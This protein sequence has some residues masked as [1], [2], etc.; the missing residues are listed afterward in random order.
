[1]ATSTS[2]KQSVV[3]TASWLPL[4]VIVLAQMQMAF[5]VNALP[6]SLGPI[7]NDLDAP[8]TAISSALLIY[9]LFVAA[10]VMLGAKI[11]KL[12][13]ERLVFQVSAVAHGA[14]MAL[15]ALATDTSMM[16][17]AQAVAG[18]AAAALVP[19]LV[20]LIAANYQDKQ[21]AQAFGIL[22]SIPAVAS[23]V[24][25]VVA[26]Y[27]ATLLNWRLSFWSLAVLSGVVLV[28]SFRLKNV[29]RTPD[30]KIDVTGV[31]LS[32]MAI[33]FILF[34]FNNI[35]TW[36]L[37]WATPNAPFS[38]LGVSP[39]LILTA[40]GIVLGQ[41]FFS[42]SHHRVA[43][44]K[45]PLLAMEVLDSP[46]EKNAV[47]AFLVAGALGTAVSFLIPL[48]IQ[49]VQGQTPFFTA[50]A[51]VP[52]AIAV[53]IAAIASVRLY[54]RLTPRI[55]GMICFVMIAVGAT[56]VGF[57][58]FNDWGTLSVILGLVI[59][60]LGEGTM[61]TLLF[62]VLVSASPK[63]FAGDVGALRGVANNVSS[64]LGAAFAG[65]VAVGLLAAVITSS[66]QASSLPSS[67]AEELNFDRIDFVS[68][69][70]LETYLAK[71]SATPAQV[72]EAVRINENA[73]LSALRA[74]FILIAIISLLALIPALGLPKYSPT[75][76]PA[77][78][79][80]TNSKKKK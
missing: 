68:N 61:L 49:F 46:E 77:D 37:L 3:Q 41:S 35:N 64:A 78:P 1:M 56:I 34:A 32:A 72:A 48:Y 53:A 36:G 4:I 13:G 29:P 23:G 11:A 60:G 63:E 70:Q 9:S 44:K 24:A 18:V 42:W 79:T 40:L 75:Q 19:T 71:T 21:Q 47:M 2:T 65:V 73:R 26:G 80:T 22:A 10:F 55:L 20:V 6:V 17:L 59:L 31:V 25:F 58:I 45:T 5:N 30:I 12:L 43:T 52:Y 54:D 76:V 50:V 67:L 33:A 39:V 8:A 74:T 28:L 38:I 51:I 15:M 7:A 66:F 16:N 62:N 69:A 27:I 14:S 57:S